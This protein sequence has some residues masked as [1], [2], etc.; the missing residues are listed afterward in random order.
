MAAARAASSFPGMPRRAA[1][2]IL[3]VLLAFPGAVVAA[4]P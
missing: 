4:R 1:A 2:L 3:V